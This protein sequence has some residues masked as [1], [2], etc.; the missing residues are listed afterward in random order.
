M[1]FH[2]EELHTIYVLNVVFLFLKSNER[3]RALELYTVKKRP[4]KFSDFIEDLRIHEIWS[5]LTALTYC[6]RGSREGYNN[7]GRKAFSKISEQ[8][9]GA[10]QTQEG[11]NQTCGAISYF[12]DVPQ[13]RNWPSKHQ[14]HVTSGTSGF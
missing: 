7:V 6:R 5:S 12:D 1:A 2:V 8:G 9:L 14:E 4:S 10:S 13:L 3:D 11:H